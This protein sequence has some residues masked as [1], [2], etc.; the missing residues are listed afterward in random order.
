VESE[1][2]HLTPAQDTGNAA[3]GHAQVGSDA[4]PDDDERGEDPEQER[5]FTD[6]KP[7]QL[8]ALK[9]ETNPMR[10][11]A[12]NVHLDDFTAYGCGWVAR[13]LPFA[14]AVGN[15]P[16]GEWRARHRPSVARDTRCAIVRKRSST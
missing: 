12:M 5:G 14:V 10:A 9:E 1:E 13:R 3:L 11:T 2:A 4:D 7:R 15:R 6:G 16:P 8:F